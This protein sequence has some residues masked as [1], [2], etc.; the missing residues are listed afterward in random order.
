[1]SE[2]NGIKKN[3]AKLLLSSQLDPEILVNI[4]NMVKNINIKNDIGVPPILNYIRNS[5]LFCVTDKLY[6][7]DNVIINENSI[8]TNKIIIGSLKYNKVE[9]FYMGKL[10]EIGP[11]TNILDLW[12]SNGN[13]YSI[14]NNIISIKNLFLLNDWF[15]VRIVGLLTSETCFRIF[16]DKLDNFII[17]YDVLRNYYDDYKKKCIKYNYSTDETIQDFEQS[18]DIYY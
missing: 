8:Y 2:Y 15:K 16:D 18:N 13:I 9:Y 7:C 1:M 17:T 14:L 10:V 4:D 5:K 3:L 12:L 6:F 11:N